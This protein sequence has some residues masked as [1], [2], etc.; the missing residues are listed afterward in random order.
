MRFR[1]PRTI[2]TDKAPE[3]TDLTNPALSLDQN[4]RRILDEQFGSAYLVALPV[5]VAERYRYKPLGVAAILLGIENGHDRYFMCLYH[6]G[7]EIGTTRFAV[8][9]APKERIGGDAD[10]Y[11]TDNLAYLHSSPRS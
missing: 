3:F 7:K 9:H 8:R 5:R 2:V 1:E 6:N 10:A 11:R 4:I